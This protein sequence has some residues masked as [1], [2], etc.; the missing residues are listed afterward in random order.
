MKRN[1]ICGLGVGVVGEEQGRTGDSDHVVKAL[2][3]MVRTWT[4][5][6]C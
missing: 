6:C 1:K 5:F 3:S 2:N 4:L